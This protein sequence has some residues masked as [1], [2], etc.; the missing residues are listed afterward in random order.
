[1]NNVTLVTMCSFSPRENVITFFRTVLE[2]M[3]TK[4][5]FWIHYFSSPVFLNTSRLLQVSRLYCV[6]VAYKSANRP[7]PS[8]AC[9]AWYDPAM[10]SHFGKHSKKLKSYDCDE[11]N[12]HTSRFCNT[13]KL[14][15][16]SSTKA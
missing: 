13:F 5:F 12:I 10:V 16:P 9:M 4:L 11:N 14:M 15:D 3:L 7:R 2:Q 8:S 6:Q 1:M